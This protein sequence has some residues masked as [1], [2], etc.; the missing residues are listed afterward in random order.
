MSNFTKEK[1]WQNGILLT[2]PPLIFN[3]I[4][5]DKLPAAFSPEIF[6]K[7]IPAFITYGENFFRSI[8]FIFPLLMLIKLQTKSQKAGLAIYILGMAIYFLSWILLI[9]LPENTWSTSLF[10][11]LAPAYTPFIWLLGLG[12]IGDTLWLSIPYKWQ[13][14][15]I[16]VIL[17]LSFHLSHVFLVFT[18]NV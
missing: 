5:A 9:S 3:L 16:P 11:F 7:N 10:G 14:Y 4:F 6:N 17:F 2:I 18:Q 12:M 13:Y 15:L 1:Y 8:V